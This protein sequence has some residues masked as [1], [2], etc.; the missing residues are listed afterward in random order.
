[1]ERVIFRRE[2][3][4]YMKEWGFLAVFPDDDCN[5]GMIAATP[6]G[7]NRDGKAF[8]E[9]YT[10]ISLPYYYGKRVVHRKD[11]MIGKLRKAIEGYYGT[12]FRVCEK[13]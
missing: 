12:T 13:I 4:P 8:F 9:P 6:F 1:M 5:M 11:P 2:Y 10:E 3:D 7:F